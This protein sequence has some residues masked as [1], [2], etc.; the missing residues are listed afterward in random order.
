MYLKVGVDVLKLIKG[1]KFRQTKMNGKIVESVLTK[2][3]TW[4]F[5]SVC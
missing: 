3:K 1:A 5:K 2:E 4:I